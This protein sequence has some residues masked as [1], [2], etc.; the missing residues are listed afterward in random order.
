MQAIWSA[1]PFLALVGCVEAPPR[2]VPSP[3]PPPAPQPPTPSRLEPS[4]YHLSVSPNTR[5]P[6]QVKIGVSE[7]LMQH[8]RYRPEHREAVLRR[9]QVESGFEPCIISGPYHY[10]LQWAGERVPHGGG[11]PSWLA[12]MEYMDR[13]IDTQE[14][15]RAFFAKSS[16]YAAYVWFSTVYLGGRM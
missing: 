13:E 10:L 12:Q 4:S 5:D 9:I 3:P 6:E 7:W 8:P 16:V 2:Q 15:W 11:C 14:N 1:L